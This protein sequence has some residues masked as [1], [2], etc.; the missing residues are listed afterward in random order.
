MAANEVLGDPG[1]AVPEL[2]PVRQV[3]LVSGRAPAV[4]LLKSIL[5]LRDLVQDTI[6][7]LNLDKVEFQPVDAQ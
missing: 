5:L 4:E 1:G 2:G 3:Q 6:R 7:V